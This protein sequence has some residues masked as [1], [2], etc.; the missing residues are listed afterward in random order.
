MKKAIATVLFGLACLP[1]AFAQQP[2]IF[3]DADHK[4]GEKL[5]A[6]HKCDTCHARKVA[7]MAQQFTSL[8]EKSTQLARFAE[9]LTTA[10]LN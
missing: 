10:A 8:K 1:V 4:L 5:I 7:A 3:K 6:E 2:G 9:W